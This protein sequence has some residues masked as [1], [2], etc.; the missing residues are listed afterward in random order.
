MI[1]NLQGQM[2]HLRVLKEVAEEQLSIIFLKSWETGEVPD[3]WR[4]AN[5]VPV[6]KKGKQEEPGNY[7]PVSLT[8]IPRQNFGTDGS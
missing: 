3:D 7:R 2:L 6:F 8:S 1:S 4:K 5:V